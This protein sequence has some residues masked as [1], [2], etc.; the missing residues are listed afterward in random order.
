M[1]NSLPENM[2][3]LVTALPATH[4]IPL[5]DCWE[6]RTSVVYRA[7]AANGD[8]LDVG[9]TADPSQRFRLHE[10]QSPFWLLVDRVEISQEFMDRDDAEDAERKAIRDGQ[11]L[12]N[13]WFPLV[14]ERA[15]SIVLNFEPYEYDNRANEVLPRWLR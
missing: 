10:F 8:L 3:D 2:T 9:V 13:R 12:C 14:P 4:R 5:V 11:P 15:E 1:I 7:Y 6:P